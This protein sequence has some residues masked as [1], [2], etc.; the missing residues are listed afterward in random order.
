M[1]KIITYTLTSQ[2]ITHKLKLKLYAW[3]FLGIVFSCTTAYSQN[4]AIQPLDKETE[5]TRLDFQYLSW[6][7]GKWTRVKI[8]E[9]GRTAFELWKKSSEYELIGM[10]ITLQGSDTAFV[11]KLKIIIIGNEIHY[12]ADVPE[13]PTPVHF[14]LTQISGN[15][16]IC[17]NPQHDYPKKISY[18]L[19]GNTLTAQTSGDGKVAEFIFEKIK[20]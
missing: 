1:T 8:K 11:E 18:Q 12:V 19:K 5:K 4:N 13:N 9:P 14:T 3:L 16:F 15:Q 10:G 20:N 7:E 2:Q 17:E 6:L